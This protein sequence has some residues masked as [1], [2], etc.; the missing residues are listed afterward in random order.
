MLTPR[1]IQS[2]EFESKLRGY[3][4]EEVDG[5]LDEIIKDFQIMIDQN[6]ILLDENRT[7]KDALN[8]YK[9]MELSMQKSIDAAKASAEQIKKNAE[10]EAEFVVKR[11]KLNVRDMEKQIDN[12]HMR[13]KQEIE[14]MDQELA[15]FRGKIKMYCTDFLDSLSKME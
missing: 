4:R 9:E 15:K 8:R 5:F 6:K 14:A 13:K 11:A 3:D 1:D 2:K 10:V 7:L 12:E